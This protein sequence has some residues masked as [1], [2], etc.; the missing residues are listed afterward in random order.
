VQESENTENNTVNENNETVDLN[1][2][3]K[4]EDNKENSSD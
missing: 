3:E 4:E 1:V 2:S